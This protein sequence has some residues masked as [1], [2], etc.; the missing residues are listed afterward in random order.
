MKDCDFY[1]INA[2]NISK[3][4]R[5]YYKDIGLVIVDEA[6]LIM[7]E[8]L[9]GC[10]RSLVP[11]YVIGL[12]ATP[13]RMDGLNVLLDM[14]FGNYKIERKLFRKHTVYRVNT[15]FSPEVKLNKMGKID[16]GTI[17]DSTCSS[18]ERNELIIRIIKKFSTRTFLVLCKR[19]NQANY[20]YER[21]LEEKEDVTSLI[22]KNQT[23]EQKSR[24]LIGTSGKV[25]T[26][27]DHPKLNAMILASDVEQY[28]IQYLGRVFR[29][30]EVEP[31]IIDIVDNHNLLVKHFKTRSAV[32]MEHG[33]IV[34]D[35]FKEFPDFVGMDKE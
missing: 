9:S 20:L 6:H 3:H 24:I 11:R 8:K 19:V 33:G 10:M 23:Y 13:Y 29:T 22:G 18:Q 31:F 5:S 2:T 12:S 32:Y 35:F 26:G 21:L 1:I 25:G 14:Y 17:L 15:G 34:K 27:F 16:W 4:P 28:F 30:Q 7:A